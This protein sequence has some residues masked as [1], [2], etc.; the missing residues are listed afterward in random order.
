VKQAYVAL[1]APVG[2]GLDFKVGVW[3]TIIGYEVFESGSNPNFTRSYGYALEPTTHTGVLAAYQFC[4]AFSATFGVANTFGPTI[5]GRGPTESYKT[6]MGAFTLTAPTNMAYLAGSTLTAGVINGFNQAVGNETSWYIGA[7]LATPVTGLKVGLAFDDLNVHDV[8]GENWVVG[9]YAA[10]QATEKLGFYA[11]AEYLKNRGDEKLFQLP[12]STGTGFYATSPDEVLGL[13]AT[14]QYDLW[15]NV[16]SRLEIRWD[17]ALRGP[18]TYGGTTSNADVGA[19]GTG[20]MKNA[21][22]LVANIIYKF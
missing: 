19:D 2:N 7:T 18:G 3:D 21:F 4:E 13:T 6:Y 14:A 20:S 12:D 17:H 15:K 22:M 1:H 9:T 10:F 5:N 8:S 11:R 16:M